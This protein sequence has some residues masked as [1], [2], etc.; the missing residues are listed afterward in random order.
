LN[1]TANKFISFEDLGFA[2]GEPHRINRQ[3]FPEAIYCPGKTTPQI[4][5]IF[6]VLCQGPGPV[7]AT[8]VTMDIARA[9]QKDFPKAAYHPEARLVVW[10][11]RKINAQTQV[12]VITG[13]TADLPVITKT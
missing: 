12:F 3:G 8:R 5:K 10:G 4:L 7:I 6:K 11:A 13:G 9:I 1:K 2:K